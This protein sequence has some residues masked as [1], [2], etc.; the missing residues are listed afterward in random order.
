MNTSNT[1][2]TEAPADLMQLQLGFE[3]QNT[4][5]T[6]Y[7]FF[8]F[9]DQLENSFKQKTLQTILIYFVVQALIGIIAIEYAW[10]RTRRFRENNTDRDE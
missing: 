4:T 3:V 2:I 1:V 8:G 5:H 9:F 10:C 6:Q 7:G